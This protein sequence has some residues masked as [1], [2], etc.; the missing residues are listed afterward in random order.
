VAQRTQVDC[1][2]PSSSYNQPSFTSFADH[3]LQFL[4]RRIVRLP[5][6]H[7]PDHL[8][9]GVTYH[10]VTTPVNVAFP[11]PTIA[12]V[13]AGAQPGVTGN[14]TAILEAVPTADLQF[15]RDLA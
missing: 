2:T 8:D 9:E 7:P 1:Q 3:R 6:C 11:P 4:D 10:R 12:V 15:E 5:A 14:L 13:D